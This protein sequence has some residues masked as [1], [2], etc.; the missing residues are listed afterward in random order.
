MYVEREIVQ[1]MRVGNVEKGQITESCMPC[2]D[3]EFRY[4]VMK[5]VLKHE[6]AEFFKCFY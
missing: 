6:N 1:K 2:S 5:P 3:K 4:Y